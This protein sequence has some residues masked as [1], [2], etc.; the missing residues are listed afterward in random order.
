MS[1][2]PWFSCSFLGLILDSFI[3]C[4]GIHVLL[5][6]VGDFWWFGAKWAGTPVLA[7][8]VDAPLE[9]DSLQ[10]RLILCSTTDLAVHRLI[11]CNETNLVGH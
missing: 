9:H 7:H 1:D 4:D 10:R 2:E 8:S 11:A 6:A 5:C 3:V